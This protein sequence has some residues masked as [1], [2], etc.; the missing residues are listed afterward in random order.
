MGKAAKGSGWDERL[1]H[2]ALA[3]MPYAFSIWDD[4]LHLVLWNQNYLDMYHFDPER[5]HVGMSLY[6]IVTLTTGVG[7]HPGMTTDDIYAVYLER[8]TDRDDGA[9]VHRYQKAIA[10][11]VIKS[12]HIRRPGLWIVTHED[13]TEEVETQRLA[14][15]RE[16]ALARQNLRFDAAVNNMPQ[17]LCMFG[18]DQRLVVC[19]DMFAEMYGL[20]PELVRPGTLLTDIFAYRV[21]NGMIPDGE[22]V[23][24]YVPSRMR[25]VE[26]HDR[27]VRF[28]ERERGRTISVIQQPVADG[29]WVSIHQDI[30]E[31]RQKEELI[32]ARTLALEVQ[33]IRFDAAVNNMSHGLSMF[34]AENRLIVCNR[35]YAEMYGLPERLTHPGTSFW[36][37]LDDGAKTGMVSI[38]DA[39]QRFRVL[40]AVID[41]G[42]P[43]KHNVK[44][45]NGRVIAVLHQ[46]MPGGGW[47]ST[48]E[49]VTEQHHHEETIRHLARHDALTDLPN[50]VLFREEMSKIEAPHQAARDRGAVL[51]RPRPLQGRQRQP[52]PRHRRRG[53][54]LR[55]PP[56]ARGGPRERRGGATGRR[57]IRHPRR[58]AR[59]PQARRRHCRSHRQVAGPANDDRWQPDHHRRQRRHRHG[60]DRRHRRRDLAEER[61]SRPLPGQG[62]RPRRLPFLRGEHGRRAQAAPRRSSWSSRARWPAASCAW[63]SSRLSASPTTA[64]CC[65]EALLRWDHPQR[66]SGLARRVHSGRRGNRPD[67]ADRRVGAAAKPAA[68][69]SRWPKAIR[70]AVNLSAVQFRSAGLVGIGRRRWRRPARPDRLELEITESLLLADTEATLATLHSLRAMGV[71]DRDGR[72]RHGLFLAQLPRSFPFDKIKIDRSFVREVS[73]APA[74]P[75]PSSAP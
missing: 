73:P 36:D 45:E 6:D 18:P 75:W 1:L 54:D 68:W 24:T 38:G 3:S 14:A 47:I 21:A 56:P 12:T 63:S 60:A 27:T 59:L 26:E 50:R 52:R 66:G 4:A 29:G 37:M 42:R 62:R 41:A 8:F 61:R 34:D 32:Q 39:E 11:R 48:H 70:V 64:I 43:F 57:R 7:N 71:R 15:A 55:F 74:M 49:D 2:A 51:H 40:S 22:R 5:V 72:F 20:P 31:Q 17:G 65:L 19:N 13:I 28:V 44:M 10:G 58:T 46:P 30:T 16:D 23:E 69:R 9:L 33:N 67:R 25:I 35:Q 53:A